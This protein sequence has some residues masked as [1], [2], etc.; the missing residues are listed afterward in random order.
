MLDISYKP[1]HCAHI[2]HEFNVH[3]III[4]N[5]RTVLMRL[6]SKRRIASKYSSTRYESVWKDNIK[7]HLYSLKMPSLLK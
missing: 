6:Q 1:I 3:N 4:I 2:A 7:S 5:M